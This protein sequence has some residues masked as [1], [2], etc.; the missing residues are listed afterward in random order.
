MVAPVEGWGWDRWYCC[1]SC[2]SRRR[3]PTVVQ[4]HLFHTSFTVRRY[5]TV[6]EVR[7]NSSRGGWNSRC[8]VLPRFGDHSA[9][10]VDG[11]AAVC[12]R[13]GFEM[14]ARARRCLRPSPRGGGRGGTRARGQGVGRDG[15]RARALVVSGDLPYHPFLQFLFP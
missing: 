10:H 14:G 2:N 1:V 11:T 15:I 9:C 3:Q 12:W 13:P 4:V 8:H 6:K 7:L 5:F